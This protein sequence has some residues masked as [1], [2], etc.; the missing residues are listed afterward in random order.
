[1]MKKSIIAV[2]ALTLVL[3]AAVLPQEAAYAHN[4]SCFL[5]RVSIYP[6][7]SYLLE[8]HIVDPRPN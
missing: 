8:Y 4:G 3:S 1:M 6:P 7:G 5:T 2:L